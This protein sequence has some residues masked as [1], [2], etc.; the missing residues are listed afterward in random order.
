LV[1]YL[2]REESIYI[3]DVSDKFK[4]D[5]KHFFRLAVRLPDENNRLV[6]IFED[7]FKLKNEYEK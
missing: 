4:D 5:S 6:Q 2:L 7:Y 1:E 3:K